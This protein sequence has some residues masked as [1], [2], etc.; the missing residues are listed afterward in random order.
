MIKFTKGNILEA[1]AEALVN[2]VNTVGVMGKGIALAFKKKFPENFK[3]YKKACDNQELETGKVLVT[4][5]G[6]FAPK[7]IVNFPTKQ[8][9]RG[10][11]KTEFI[12][13]G[14]QD[15]LLV[16]HNFKIKSI[17]IPPL[18]SGNGGLDWND[19]KPIILKHLDAIK[20][21]TDIIIYEPGYN[22]QAMNNQKI[23]NLTPARGM[24]LSALN[25]YLV[26][27]YSANL[28]VLQKLA[29]FLQKLGEP[30]NLTFEKGFYGPYSHQLQHLLKYLNGYYLQ[31][32]HEETAPGTIIKLNYAEKIEEYCKNNL[33]T[34][35]R[36]RLNSLK[37]LIEGF[38]SPYGLELLATVN[39][40]RQHKG[41]YNADTIVNEIGNWTKR[42]KELMKPYHIQVA[43]TRLNDFFYNK[44]EGL[45]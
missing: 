40:I 27:G 19:V 35:Q 30:L 36:E 21:E 2:T 31:F 9:W 1:E 38:E 25:S 20:N 39:F 37:Q 6:Q 15:L 26:L 29:Y 34:E 41:L 33:S 32:K 12:E 22:N 23:V 28:L 8:H 14:L 45:S 4:Q 44:Q 43:N 24:L 3:I 7:F 11:S 16:V 5:T 13:Q 17:A 18:G 10:K 42:K